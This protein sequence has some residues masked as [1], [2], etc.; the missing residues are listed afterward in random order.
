MNGPNPT[1]RL[2][3]VDDDAAT[4]E[5][6]RLRFEMGGYDVLVAA[7]GAEGLLLAAEGRPDLI[8]LDFG[9]PDMDGLAV[10]H[11]LRRTPPV[12]A[13]PVVM[14]TNLDDGKLRQAAIAL[15][16][17]E[18]VVKS[19]MLPGAIASH[20]PEWVGGAAAGEEAI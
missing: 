4:R 13:V 10:L 6:Y 3:L 12:S 19:Q 2:L 5:M 16:V 20:V 1:P 7:D 14:L 9:L 11:R 15:G 17:R 8:F 18:W